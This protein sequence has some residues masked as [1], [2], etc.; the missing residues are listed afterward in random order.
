MSDRRDL[1]A[2]FS[3]HLSEAGL[4]DAA[5][6]VVVAVSGGGDSAG[7]LALLAGVATSAGIALVPAHVAHGLRGEE[8]ARDA[9]AAA[10]LAAS[11]GLG[12]ALRPV[13][14]GRL[15]RKGESL[16]AASRRLRYASLLALAAELGPGTL[17]ATGHTLDDQAE[18]V[19][20]N[21]M[22]RAGRSRGGIRARRED[23][24]VRPLLP[25]RRRELRDFLEAEGISW[26]EDSSNADTR[27]DRN[28][29]RHVDLPALEARWPGT[30][31]RLARAGAAWSAR[32][33]RLDAAIDA[34]LASARASLD[35]PWPRE[36]FR[37]L[38]PEASG[39]LL[40]R[41]AGDRGRVPGRSQVARAV[42]RVLS[43]EPR[44]AETLAGL[45]LAA[46]ARVVRLTGL[47]RLGR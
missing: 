34:A 47:A 15:R 43:P 32:L 41:S 46:D 1:S 19:L 11:L 13:D 14:V 20:L 16:E 40:V 39:R 35:G 31:E 8:G 25:F 5:R 9:R 22:R 23:G 37:S 27:F 18:T 2:R 6:T 12:F 3:A 42:A 4:L 38:G 33:A 10:D 44:V 17:V 24:V 29:V 36:L 26:R 30:T 21:L 7:L 45:R 28:R